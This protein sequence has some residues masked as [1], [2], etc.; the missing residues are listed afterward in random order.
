[1][2]EPCSFGQCLH[3]KDLTD[4]LESDRWSKNSHHMS[5]LCIPGDWINIQR[6]REMKEVFVRAMYIKHSTL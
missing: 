5:L 1:M 6:F 3:C 2:K 4:E